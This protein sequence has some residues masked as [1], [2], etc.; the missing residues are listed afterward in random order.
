MRKAQLQP[1]ERDAIVEAIITVDTLKMIMDAAKDDDQR[2]FLLALAI[3]TYL[4]IWR[5]DLIA[6]GG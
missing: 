2:G 1:D 6:L 4:P 5:S 3:G